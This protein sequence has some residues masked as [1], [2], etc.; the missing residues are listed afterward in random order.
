MKELYLDLGMGA[1]GDMLTAALAGLIDDPA[2]SEEITLRVF[3]NVIESVRNE[4]STFEKLIEQICT[5]GGT[6]E[7]GMN[8]LQNSSLNGIINQ[9]L[10]SAY[11]RVSGLKGE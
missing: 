1:A 10:D 4:G 9:C 5:K 3:E 7:A 11:A 2:V 6:T 8:I